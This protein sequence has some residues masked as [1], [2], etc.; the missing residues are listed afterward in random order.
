MMGR[1][2][3]PLDGVHWTTRQRWSWHSWHTFDG[4]L[5]QFLL[6]QTVFQGPTQK[7]NV[8]NSSTGHLNI[9]ERGKQ[10]QP[11]RR[12]NLL[13]PSQVSSD[14]RMCRLGG[15]R[16]QMNGKCKSSRTSQAALLRP[17]TPAINRTT[18]LHDTSKRRVNRLAKKCQLSILAQSCVSTRINEEKVIVSAATLSQLAP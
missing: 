3:W 13:P 18:K 16:N 14:R 2:K 15:K 12:G 11:I 8:W 10:S 6:F 7:K 17:F 1:R 4:F 5:P 9:P